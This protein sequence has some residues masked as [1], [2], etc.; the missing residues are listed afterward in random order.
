MVK[1]F[2]TVSY[3]SEKT[4]AGV[5]MWAIEISLIPFVF[6]GSKGG[7]SVAVSQ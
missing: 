2:L 5:R 6:S 3:L 1:L 4:T 7:E